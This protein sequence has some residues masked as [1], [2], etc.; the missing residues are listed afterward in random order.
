MEPPARSQQVE[1]KDWLSQK[2]TEAKPMRGFRGQG[3]DEGTLTG[4]PTAD[5]LKDS[6]VG[7]A[8]GSVWSPY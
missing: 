4:K 5:L 3:F 1:L 7:V 6:E 8:P 2:D